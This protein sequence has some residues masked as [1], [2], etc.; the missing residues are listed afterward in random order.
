M[1][2]IKH[3]VYLMLENRS[4]DNVLGWL[5]DDKH[6]PKVNIP[7][8]SPPTYDGLKPTYFN[9]DKNGNQ[10]FVI[11]G[12]NHNLNVP[13]CDPH[14]EYSHVNAQLFGH[15]ANPA[16]LTAAPMLGFYQDFSYFSNPIEQ[17]FG[18]LTDEIMMSYTPEE[19]PVLNG[20]AK[21]FAVSDR[22]FS[23]VPTQS[24]CN[25]AFAACGNSLGK[26]KN[27]LEAWVND[28]HSAL[29]GAGE[30]EGD[31][32]SQK[33]MWNVLSECG[34]DSSEDWMIYNSTGSGVQNFFGVEGYSYTRDLMK[35]LQSP[36]LNQHFDTIDTFYT[37][38]KEGSL[39]SVCF[40]EPKWGG[41]YTERLSEQ[42]NDYHPPSNLAPGEAFVKQIYDALTANKGAWGETLLIINFDE[43]GGTYDHVAPPWNATPPWQNSDTPKPDVCELGFEFDRFGVRVPLILVS[44]H[45]KESTVFRAAGDIPY[46]HTSVI[47]TILKTMGIPKDKW[48]LG[49]RTANAPTFENVFTGNSLRTNIPPISI[50]PLAKTCSEIEKNAP[51]NDI[52]K[53]RA[54]FIDNKLSSQ[55]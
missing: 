2:N 20:L 43:H 50:N 49:G 4:F 22:Y 15:E 42:G 3:I 25:R 7:A 45:V 14:E 13:A 19:L 47:A 6:P 32:F 31:Q 29:F 35:Q 11:K 9:L 23:S 39:P 5:Y 33:T 36:T 54:Q 40:L 12:T 16:K 27:R 34:R 46:D 51:Q 10:H 17:Y 21:H 44:P 37:R 18:V 1:S 52:Q 55:G 8:Q 30:P 24:N 48:G 38:A 26:N 28:R 53:R 41:G